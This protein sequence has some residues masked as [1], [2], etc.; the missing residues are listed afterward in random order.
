MSTAL[1]DPGERCKDW[2]LNWLLFTLNLKGA[3]EKC[4]EHGKSVKTLE[5]KAKKYTITHLYWLN[6]VLLAIFL[7]I[8]LISLP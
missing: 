2:H 1:H 7:L 4:A 5:S 3:A 8:S 6:I